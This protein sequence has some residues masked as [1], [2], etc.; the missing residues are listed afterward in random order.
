MVDKL[1]IYSIN[2][3]M[4]IIG[5]LIFFHKKLLLFICN[6]FLPCDEKREKLEHL[7]TTVMIEGKRSMGKTM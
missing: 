2:W 1:T 6:L 7:V 4:Q 3:L 5:G